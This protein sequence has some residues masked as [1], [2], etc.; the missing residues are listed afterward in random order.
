MNR[1]TVTILNE[2]FKNEKTGAEVLGITIIMDG[3]LK[4]VAD[5]LMKK[6][7]K[8]KNY[9]EIVRDAFFNGLNSMIEEHRAKDDSLY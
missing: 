1:N 9:T 7:P 4:E 6:D 8:Y 2:E 5:L 3:K